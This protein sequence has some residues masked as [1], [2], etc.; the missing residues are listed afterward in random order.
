MAVKGRV[1]PVTNDPKVEMVAAPHRWTKLEFP[2]DHH[3]A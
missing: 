2:R 3:A 1:V